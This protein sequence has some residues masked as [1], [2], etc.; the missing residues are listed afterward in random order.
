MVRI[1]KPDGSGATVQVDPSQR[2]RAEAADRR[3]NP[4]GVLRVDDR[5]ESISPEQ[6]Q[7]YLGALYE[8]GRA[9]EDYKT[10]SGDATARGEIIKAEVDQRNVAE[11]ERAVPKALTDAWGVD[12]K[13]VRHR[14]HSWGA[15]YNVIVAGQPSR[16][17]IT[18]S[19]ADTVASVATKIALASN[20]W[21]QPVQEFWQQLG[22][23]RWGEQKQRVLVNLFYQGSF[24][25]IADDG[26][27]VLAHRVVGKGFSEIVSKIETDGDRLVITLG[28]GAP[29]NIKG[30]LI[31]F[32]VP[33]TFYL[34]M[35]HEPPARLGIPKTVFRGIEARHFIGPNELAWVRIGD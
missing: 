26:P 12:V 6:W 15:D 31:I 19:G 33:S 25:N 22:Q 1:E 18:I 16:E 10:H 13:L 27:T 21:V 34:E 2:D 32:D 4:D 5:P 35:V 20:R 11:L 9:F 23:G 14:E 7:T 17:G 3:G 29:T 24:G 28:A 30:R 8:A